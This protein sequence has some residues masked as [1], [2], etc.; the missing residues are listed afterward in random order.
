MEEL[1]KVL[2]YKFKNINYLKIGLTHSSYANEHK[3][4]HIKE[5]ALRRRAFS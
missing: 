4:L 1:E 3:K 2:D 5:S